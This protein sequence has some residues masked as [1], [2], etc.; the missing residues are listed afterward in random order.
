[1]SEYKRL[2]AIHAGK[3]KKGLRLALTAG[4][5]KVR[6]LSVSEQELEKAATSYGPNVVRYTLS[7]RL[8]QALVFSRNLN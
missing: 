1:M 8:V 4:L 2:I 3:P 5:D 6:R 7:V